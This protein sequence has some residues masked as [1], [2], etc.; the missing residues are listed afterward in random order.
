LFEIKIN[1]KIK[2][3][4]IIGS[5]ITIVE[6]LLPKIT[7]G[8]I[9]IERLD[10]YIS[11]IEVIVEALKEDVDKAPKSKV[12]SNLGLNTFV[13]CSKKDD[14]QDCIFEATD[15]PDLICDGMIIRV[16]HYEDMQIACKYKCQKNC[17]GYLKDSKGCENL[18]SE[19]NESSDS[20]E[21]SDSNVDKDESKK[22]KFDLQE[23]KP[24]NKSDIE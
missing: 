4:K 5:H 9:R 13:N 8:E 22:S 6:V 17:E 15:L 20:S 3:G 19:N 10:G 21:S 14:N 7:T 11:M 12:S 1:E 24:P 23:V 2:K 18:K 16:P